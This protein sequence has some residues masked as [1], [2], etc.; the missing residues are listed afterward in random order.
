MWEASAA[1]LLWYGAV[2]W[3]GT[4]WGTLGAAEA[5]L[6]VIALLWMAFAIVT[7]IFVAYDRGVNESAYWV[8]AIANLVT[9][10]VVSHCRRDVS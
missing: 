4:F 10:V 8:L 9:L 2:A 1:A 7:E 3:D 5:G 6:I